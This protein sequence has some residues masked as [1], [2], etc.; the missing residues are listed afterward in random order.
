[1]KSRIIRQGLIIFV[2]CFGWFI[3]SANAQIKVKQ[4]YIHPIIIAHYDVDELE[5]VEKTIQENPNSAEA[6][7]KR[8]LIR[9][10]SQED[11]AGA[12]ADFTHVIDLEPSAEVYNYRGT[13][14]FWLQQ[15]QN[16]LEDYQRA[17]ALDQNLAIAY[18]NRAYVYLELGNKAGAIADFR[19]GAILSQEQG[20]SLS[21]QQAL[22]LIQDL[23]IGKKKSEIMNQQTMTN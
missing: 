10:H 15:Y 2:N 6:Y 1:M 9:S 22:D 14:Y 12:I 5:E 21:Y 23:E 4:N 8:G 3:L 19:Q 17:I 18:Y 20:D 13:A 16:A 11:F 7:L